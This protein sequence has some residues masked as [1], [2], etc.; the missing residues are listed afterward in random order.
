MDQWLPK[1]MD[2]RLGAFGPYERRVRGPQ[3]K[4]CWISS[5][6]NPLRDLS[7]QKSPEDQRSTGRFC[8]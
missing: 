7:Q 8:L 4:T 2:I 3:V 1:A 6:L 5:S